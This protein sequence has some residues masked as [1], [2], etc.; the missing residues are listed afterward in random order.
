MCYANWRAREECGEFANQ[1]WSSWERRRSI[2][3]A[4]SEIV[5]GRRFFMRLP[6]LNQDRRIT[7]WLHVDLGFDSSRLGH[8]IQLLARQDAILRDLTT[9]RDFENGR[10][11]YHFGMPER[12]A[13]VTLLV[14]TSVHK[15]RVLKRLA[16]LGFIARIVPTSE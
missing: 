7:V 5:G 8:L 16:D 9:D 12:F 10:T 13:E 2:F 3:S 14:A 11:V 6:F 1:R 4:D 15:D